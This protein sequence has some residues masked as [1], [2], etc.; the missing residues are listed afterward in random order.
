MAQA[1][2]I[3]KRVLGPGDAGPTVL[4][5]S[6]RIRGRLSGE[7]DVTVEGSIE[8]AVSVSG[9]LVVAEGATILATE[10]LEA[11]SATI[12]GHVEGGITA[13]GAV[14]LTASSR[15]RGDLKGSEVSIEEGAEFAGRI[16]AIFDLPAELGGV[17][18]R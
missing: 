6:V 9:E 11:G 16:D 12:G 8:G 10:A 7:G 17:R 1:K 4:S 2:T 5:A 14:H 3:T 15:V 13:G 18:G